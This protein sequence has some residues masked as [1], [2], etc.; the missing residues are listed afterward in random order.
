M[1]K[2][3]FNYQIPKLPTIVLPTQTFTKY[4][5]QEADKTKSNEIIFE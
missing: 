1:N 3:T 5:R 2:S 4:T